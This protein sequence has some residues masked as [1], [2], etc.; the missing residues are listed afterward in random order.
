M[1]L[2]FVVIIGPLGNTVGGR[3][4]DEDGEELVINRV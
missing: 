3:R 4:G 1:Y 2:A